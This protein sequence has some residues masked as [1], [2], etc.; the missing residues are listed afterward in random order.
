MFSKY[1]RILNEAVVANPDAIDEW[2][3]SIVDTVNLP[4]GKKWLLTK[5]RK[6]LF[7]TEAILRQVD[8]NSIFIYINEIPPYIRTALQTGSPVFAF[9]KHNIELNQFYTEINHII[10]YLNSLYA[11][12]QITPGQ[13]GMT[14]ANAAKERRLQE[15][16]TAL[17]SKL[18][19]TA[20]KDIKAQSDKWYQFVSQY[21]DLSQKQDGIDI[22]MDW[23]KHYAVSYKTKEALELDGTDLANCLRYAHYQDQIDAG[24]MKIFSIRERSR[25]GDPTKDKAV[26]AMSFRKHHP[27]ENYDWVP[28]E[29]K[30]YGNNVPAIQYHGMIVDFLNNSFK[31]IGFR[32]FNSSSDLEAMDI[33]YNENTKKYGTFEDIA[34]VIYDQDGMKIVTAKNKAHIGV[35]RVG[36]RITM[37]RHD[38]ETFQGELAEIKY[39]VGDINHVGKQNTIKA[40]GILKTR[41]SDRL[42]IELENEYGIIYDWNT[43][44]YGTITDDRFKIYQSGDLKAFTGPR[45]ILIQKGEIEFRLRYNGGGIRFAALGEKYLL[46]VNNYIRVLEPQEFIDIMNAAKLTFMSGKLGEYNEFLTDYVVDHKIWHNQDT[47]KV[48]FLEN[49]A[50]KIETDNLIAY[51]TVP[52][53]HIH[54]EHPIFVYS[55]SQKLSHPCRMIYVSF[56]PIRDTPRISHSDFHEG[57]DDDYNNLLNALGYAPN[58]TAIHQMIGRSNGG[59]VYNNGK[60]QRLTDLDPY[61]ETDTAQLFQLD[62]ISGFYYKLREDGPGPFRIQIAPEGRIESVGDNHAVRPWVKDFIKHIQYILTMDSNYFLSSLVLNDI[63]GV[64]WDNYVILDMDDL[65]RLF[66]RMGNDKFIS[67]NRK[68]YF[69]GA[70][71]RL[72]SMLIEIVTR[73]SDTEHFELIEKAWLYEKT[74]NVED[75]TKKEDGAIVFTIFPLVEWIKLFAG[76]DNEQVQ[77]E[78]LDY[79]KHVLKEVN[80]YLSQFEYPFVHFNYSRAGS[81]I[82]EKNMWARYSEWLRN[83]TNAK[84][85]ALH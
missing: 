37:S 26:V 72:K 46:E 41:P 47:K 24:I 79:E 1:S 55:K 33:T 13:W 19:Q 35:G 44:E 29:C 67:F 11:A 71:S 66:K 18:E 5:V 40:L 77:Q 28:K 57:E 85:D 58:S 49:V 61:F 42:E 36:L 31:N 3:G 12:V 70:E 4:E 65:L 78:A 14:H 60:Y 9:D 59:V 64:N 54:S 10:D 51:S 2:L 52:S 15:R 73:G 63:G 7:N 80:D 17:I 32:I 16:A 45:A 22:V 39:I 27:D 8:D 84:L 83:E 82:N 76:V 53:R 38:Y 21:R 43:L 62:G 48:G 20:Y 74:F 81:S 69:S 34:E 6:H 25:S 56:A 30:G 75:K 50:T 68:A 23:G